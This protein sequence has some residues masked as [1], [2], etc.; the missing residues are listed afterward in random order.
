MQKTLLIK[1]M[2]I[3]NY[4]LQT[5]IALQ[6]NVHVMQNYFY[7]F[8]VVLVYKTIYEFESLAIY[9]SLRFM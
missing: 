4:E 2:F 5:I 3:S 1:F 6:R 9:R 7:F 8:F